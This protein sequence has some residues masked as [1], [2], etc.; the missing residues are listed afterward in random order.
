MHAS[1]VVHHPIRRADLKVVTVMS[2]FETW[3]TPGRR[4]VPDYK[5]LAG[6]I[7]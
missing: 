3:I 6:K 7:G 1:P 4:L 2:E 5:A